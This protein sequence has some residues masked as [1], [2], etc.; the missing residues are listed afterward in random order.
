VK[1]FGDFVLL[2]LQW[3]FILWGVALVAVS[4][5]EFNVQVEIRHGLSVSGFESSLNAPPVHQRLIQ[6]VTT[7]LVA[8]GLSIAPFYLRRVLASRRPQ[9]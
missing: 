4:L 3:L 7:G 8:M 6:G 1:R 9:E 5:V 2:S